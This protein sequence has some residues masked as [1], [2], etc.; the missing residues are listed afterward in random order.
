MCY[1][2]KVK[3]QISGNKPMYGRNIS[4]VN[5]YMDS[6]HHDN[7]YEFLKSPRWCRTF[8]QHYLLRVAS[9]IIYARVSWSISV[10]DV[11]TLLVGIKV[12]DDICGLLGNLRKYV[13]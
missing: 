11:L 12:Y 7:R 10:L 1:S 8:V 4:Q 13:Q 9:W 6:G 2:G 5:I 3:N